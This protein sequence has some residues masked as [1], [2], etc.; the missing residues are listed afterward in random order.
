MAAYFRPARIDEA[1]QH[2][3][4]GP[5]TILAGGTD[6]YAARVGKPLDETILDVTAIEGLRAISEQARHWRIGAAVTW[7][8]VLE[9]AWPPLMD[10]LK[11]AAREIGGLQV[12]NSGT[13]AG[14]LCNA[15]PAADGVPA[16]LALDAHVELA[17]TR[18]LRV[19]TLAE[20]ILGPRRTARRADE[21]LSAILVPKPSHA[22]RSHFLKL[23]AREYLVISIA[24]ASVAIEHADGVVR[25]ARIAVGACSPVATRLT[26]LEHALRGQPM[27]TSLADHV[28]PEHLASLAP[29][30]DVR[31]SAAYRLDAA[32]TVVKRTLAGACA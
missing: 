17:S 10:G 5:L 24:M 9:A 7:T 23:G 16:L 2:L 28:R 31:A 29:I 6:Y 13:L 12:Q 20:F 4:R 25:G 15:S 19:L 21:M 22:A 1:L 27:D 11:L 3:A 30:G 26:V 8:D 32:L 18:G 14:N